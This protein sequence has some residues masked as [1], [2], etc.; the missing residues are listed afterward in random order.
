MA[1]AQLAVEPDGAHA[2]ISTFLA[3]WGESG[4]GKGKGRKGRKGRT[5]SRGSRGSR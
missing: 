3:R 5:R 4:D 2:F 1:L